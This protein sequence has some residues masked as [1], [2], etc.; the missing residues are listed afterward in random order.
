MTLW[1]KLLLVLLALLI[2]S[3]I[4]FAYRRY[5]LG[6]LNAAIQQLNSQ[7]T[8]NKTN[9]NFVEFK[10]VGHVHSFLGGHSNGG[11]EEIIAAAKSNQL[12]FVVMTEHMSDNF[13]TADMTLNG[14]YGGVLFINGNEATLPD[15]DRLLLIPG[16]GGSSGFV[17]DA[18]ESVGSLTDIAMRGRGEKGLSVVAYPQEF[19]S[20][21]T[22]YYNGV[23][24]YN[25]YTNAQ[26]INPVVMFFDALWSYRSYPELLFANFFRRPDENLQKWDELIATRNRRVAGFAGNDAH[27]NVGISLVD[28]SGKQL[29]GLKLD[30]Y[31]RSF[32]LVRLHV[33]LPS[34]QSLS[35]D[36]L[37]AAL[38][39]GHSFIGFDVFGDTSGFSFTASNGTES[40]IQGDEIQ[41]GTGVTLTMNVE[42]ITPTGGRIKFFRD[43]VPVWEGYGL[44]KH[45]L[46]VTQTGSYRVEVYLPQLGKPV[47]DQPWI[48][49]N[50]IYVR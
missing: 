43:G 30:P 29:V 9:S 26:Q 42:T 36:S 5:R 44:G 2:I 8:R 37:L 45:E 15:S 47:G 41:L 12:D 7:R 10:G 21:D 46:K 19:R 27:S 35:R 1:K 32:R 34:A 48:I 38:Q 31:E 11:F 6:R 28:A 40:K 22:T 49:S 17:I 33:L 25:L 13:N 39:A 50:P 3:Q 20:W 23:E 24:V 4:P 14:N 16:V 18:P